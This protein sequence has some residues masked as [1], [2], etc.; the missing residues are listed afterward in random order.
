[1]ATKKHTWDHLDQEKDNLGFT[2]EPTSRRLHFLQFLQEKSH[3]RFLE[4]RHSREVGAMTC[5]QLQ[6][7]AKS[8]RASLPSG[9]PWCHQDFSRLVPLLPAPFSQDQHPHQPGTA[10]AF[11]CSRQPRSTG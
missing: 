6:A 11:P 2:P 1:M 10:S 9:L 5:T 8:H 3:R 4:L 7:L